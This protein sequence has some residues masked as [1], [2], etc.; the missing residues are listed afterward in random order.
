MNDAT[1]LRE[2][3][4]KA[5]WQENCLRISGGVACV[6]LFFLGFIMFKLPFEY[7]G[8]FSTG[9]GASTASQGLAIMVF[10]VAAAIDNIY[11]FWF[12]QSNFGF[13]RHLCG[14]GIFYLLLGFYALP[15]MEMLKD[16]GKGDGGWGGGPYGGGKGKG[17]C[18]IRTLVKGLNDAGALPGGTQCVNDEN[19]LFVAGLPYDTT[20]CDL[21]KMFSPFG[22]VKGVRA[23]L[24][25]DTGLCQGTGFVNMMEPSGPQAAITTLNGTMLPD[26]TWLTVNVK[27]AGGKGKGDEGKGKGPTW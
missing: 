6:G 25:R 26:G 16:M 4:S 7:S 5:S 14:R 13:L 19:T 11:G 10:T 27:T 15:L 21:Y 22:P 17:K 12:I 8:S 9:Q 3:W 18:S 1:H 23:M 20:D 2:S 24:D